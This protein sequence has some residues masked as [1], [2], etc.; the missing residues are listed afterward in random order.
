M[1]KK[2]Y[3]MDDKSCIIF[4][5]FIRNRYRVRSEILIRMSH[6]IDVLNRENIIHHTI[7]N[8]LADDLNKC[9]FTLN[10]AYNDVIKKY[11]K[12]DKL[13]FKTIPPIHSF[14]WYKPFL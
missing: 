1:E 11:K 6:H 7:R 9:I 2:E 5:Y 10:T 8:K 3:I 13:S 4:R 14:F 12:I